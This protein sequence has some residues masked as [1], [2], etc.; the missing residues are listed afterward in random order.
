MATWWPIFAKNKLM[1]QSRDI[2]FGAAAK[3]IIANKSASESALQLYF[4]IEYYRAAM[5][6][7]ELEEAGLVG[8]PMG[9]KHRKVLFD[10]M[11]GFIESLRSQEDEI[12]E[13]E[14]ILHLDF[15]C[16]AQIYYYFHDSEE[17]RWCIYLRWRHS[18]PWTAELVRCD[19]SWK[20]IYEEDWVNLIE[21][22]NHLP[23]T[24]TGYYREDEYEPLMEE[25]LRKVRAMFKDQGI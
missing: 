4:G 20:F 22:T 23:G 10:S 1:E 8:L 24:V 14:W 25:A 16:P 19:E 17:R 9:A 15:F 13:N 12:R 6:M 18:D 7:S 11:L 3:F 21:E 2:L 5:I